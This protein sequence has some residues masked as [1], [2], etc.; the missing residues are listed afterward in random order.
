MNISVTLILVL[1]NFTTA[2]RARIMV[3]EPLSNTCLVVDMAARDLFATFTQLETF[4]ANRT[5][6]DRGGGSI[7]GG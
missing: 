2:K 3:D 1:K 4:H 5:N 6:I 7:D